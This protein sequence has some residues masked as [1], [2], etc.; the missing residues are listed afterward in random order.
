MGLFGVSCGTIS[1]RTTPSSDQRG[2]H[3]DNLVAFDV[4]QHVAL[5]IELINLVFQA[6]FVAFRVAQ[7]LGLILAQPGIS[8]RMTMLMSPE[9]SLISTRRV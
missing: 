4:Q 6:G 3:N 1:A 5:V 7:Q 9:K 2:A 8:G